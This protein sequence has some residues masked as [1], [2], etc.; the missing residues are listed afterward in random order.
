MKNYNKT[1]RIRYHFYRDLGYSSVEARKLSKRKLDLSIFKIKDERVVKD[2]VFREYKKTVKIPDSKIS[3]TSKTNK[4]LTNAR[5]S[6][7]KIVRQF[8]KADEND[9]TLSSWGRMTSDKRFRDDTAKTVNKIEKSLNIT[10]NQAYY[11]LYLMYH[12]GM[13]WSEVKRQMKVD[14][15]F[16]Q[17]KTLNYKY[18]KRR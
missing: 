12:D 11:F 18:N 8:K 1:V 7:Y 17:Y 10:N 2:K 3:K 5:E 16:E 14:P 15:N 9:T 13:S 4:E 6:S